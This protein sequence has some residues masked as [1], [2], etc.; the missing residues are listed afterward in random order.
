MSTTERLEVAHATAV[1]AYADAVD[2]Y[3]AAGFG[4]A[5]A[6]RWASQDAGHVLDKEIEAA[7]AH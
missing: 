3:L 4:E 6:R 1:A 5:T 7:L 2:S